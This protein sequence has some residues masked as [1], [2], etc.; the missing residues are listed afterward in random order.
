VDIVLGE[1]TGPVARTYI[2]ECKDQER[3]V[4]TAQYD[5]F[6]GRLTAAKAELGAKTQ[7]IIVASTAFV[8]EAVAQSGYEEIQLITLAELEKTIIDFRQ[9]VTDLTNTLNADPSLRYF[10][11]PN[12]RPENGIIADPATPYVMQWIADP[13]AN[14]LTLLG[15]YGTG[16]TTFLK[17]LAKYLA[18]TYVDMVIE[19]GG[20][21]RVPIFIDLREYAKSLSIR[22]LVLDFLVSHS[23]RFASYAAFEYMLFEGHVI[24]IIDGFDEMASKGDPQVT[25]RNF[26]ELNHVA[27]GRAKVILSCRTHY[28][29]TEDDLQRHHG[30]SPRL[31]LRGKSYTDLYREI[32]ARPNFMIV[33]L[34]DFDDTQV[35]A[36][37]T[38]RCGSEADRVS[39]FIEKTYNLPELSRRPVLLDMIVSSHEKLLHSAEAISPSDL[40]DVYTDIWLTQ[41]DW[42]SCLD[43]P[44][45]CILLE[46]FANRTFDDPSIQCHYTELPR[47]IVDWRKD[48]SR[49]DIEEIDREL[50]TASF[51]VRDNSG[52]YR[53]SHKSFLEYFYARFLVRDVA[54][55]KGD[56][57]KGRYFTTEVY[58]FLHGLLRS[59][60][61][62]GKKLKLRIESCN[63]EEFE[64]ANAIK[65]LGGID[66]AG[67]PMAL[68][69]ALR[70]DKSDRVRLSAATALALYPVDGIC[71]QLIKSFHEDTSKYVRSNCL[72][73]I[74]RLNNDAS[75]EFLREFVERFD[76]EHLAESAIRSHFYAALRYCMDWDIVRK[77]IERAPVRAKGHETIPTI[78]ELCK[79]NPSTESTMYCQRLMAATESPSLVASAITILP[80][81]MANSF[82]PKIHEL[83]RRYSGLPFVPSLITTLRGLVSERTASFLVTVIESG[84]PSE[85]MSAIDVVFEDYPGLFAE[86][87]SRWICKKGT[88]YQIRAAVAKSY[89]K[90]KTT[91]SLSVLMDILRRKDRVVMQR[92]ALDLIRT[93]F[94]NYVKTAV[95]VLW[96]KGIVPGVAQYSLEMLT[97]GDQDSAI[98]L[99][100]DKGVNA[101][102]TGVRVAA[103]AALSHVPTA[104]GTGALLEL[105]AKDHSVWVRMQALRS[106][107]IPGR[108]ISRDEVI[109]ASMNEKDLKVLQLRRDLLGL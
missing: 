54:S 92:T 51:L 72:A 74:V 25:L 2:V 89:G 60:L 95:Q 82:A 73:A 49:P 38:V 50:R 26:R 107:C 13:I 21:A 3:P 63:Y 47:L 90:L 8:K 5:A 27:R 88:P 81:D 78:L 94:P 101:T 35:N 87:A 97:R 22:Q 29:T 41:N 40:Y 23:I 103:C 44:T 52:N 24:L 17:H 45:K 28:F 84:K 33:H 58:G 91:D 37:V 32:S 4:S 48:M 11:E 42:C 67:L 57:W 9:Y 102:R 20:Y 10:I 15:D 70:D 69:K 18:A 86:N 1:K 79:Q 108:A 93:L 71:E 19:R 56:A 98:S 109:A 30:R 31:Q 62:V 104:K 16:K 7:G 65:C 100:L 64:R 85:A 34:P 80:K 96:E 83:I 53:F 75:C 105:L 46:M 55:G 39:S 14:Q 43:V 66:I 77:S 99:L 76:F 36:Y 6:R 106:L 61:D 59:R 68:S 12:L